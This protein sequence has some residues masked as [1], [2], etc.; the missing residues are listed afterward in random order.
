MAKDFYNILG[1]KNNATAEEIKKSFRRLAHEHHPD[2]GGD[3][4]KFKDIN[5]AYQV[6]GDA[7]KRK[8]YD[9]FGSAAFDPST[10]SGF[11]R[12]GGPQGGFGFDPSGFS[13]NMEDM[14][15]I[16][17]MFGSMFGFGGR[18]KGKRGQ[19]VEV[20]VTLK[21]RE[22]VFGA[23]K[24]I[25]LYVHAKCS[26]CDGTGAEK[27]TAVKQ[28]TTCNG[29]GAVRRIQRT[30]FG[31]VQT[32]AACE[33][34]SGTGSVSEKPCSTCKGIGVERRTKTMTIEVP[35]GISDGEALK[36][37]GEGEYPGANGRAGDLYVRF[38]VASDP[39]FTREG[40]DVMSTVEAPFSTLALGGSISVET[41]EGKESLSIPSGTRPGTVFRLRGKGVPFLRSRGRGDHHVTVIP[42]VP[43]NLTR[44]QKKALEDLKR[45]GL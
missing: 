11:A 35:A 42:A 2:K 31:S 17:E 27:G 3:A 30:V 14:G 33:T 12:G 37:N 41:V 38:R 20:D 44:E 22:A 23:K 39:T 7:E 8:Q 43:K 5:E 40:N 34:C 9:R 1:V 24:D 15:D 21:F 29:T 32:A 16:G 18:S 36:F 10:S 26:G 6:L 4:S 28:C 45:E 19:D 13:V 25:S